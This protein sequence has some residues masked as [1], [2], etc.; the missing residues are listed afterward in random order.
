M[1]C[2][3]NFSAGVVQAFGQEYLRKPTQADV[4][5]LLVVAEAHDFPGMLGCIDYMHWELRNCPSGWK[6]EF[7][8]GHYKVLTLILEAVASYDLWI[9]HAF[10]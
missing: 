4:D 7:V 10:V 2:L 9:W 1:E 6:G 8:E 5:R 3:K